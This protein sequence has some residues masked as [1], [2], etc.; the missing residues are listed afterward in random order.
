MADSTATIAPGGL[1]GTA[2]PTVMISN[3]AGVAL[4]S[5]LDANPSANVTINP[6][7]VE[8]PLTVYNQLASF[9][10][11]GPVTGSNALK[12]DMVAVGTNMYMAGESYDPLGELYGANGYAVANGTSFATPMLTGAAAMVLQSN[13]SWT[14]AQVKS[15][16]VDSATTDVTL[17]DSGDAVTAQS[18]GAGKLDAGLAMAATVTASPATISFGAITRLST[19]QQ[20]LLTNSGSSSVG[21]TIGNA[22]VH[23]ASGVAMTF[24]QSTLTLAA[25]ASTTL[26]VTLSGSVPSP[27]S[28]SGAVT[29]TGQNVSMRVPYLYLATSGTA[30]NI[31]PI[32]GNDYD[33]TVN[34]TTYIAFKLTDASGLPVTSTLIRFTA[35]SGDRVVAADATTNNYGI[36]LAEVLL[37]S[38]PGTYMF[39]ASAAGQTCTFTASARNVPAITAAG[40]VSAGSASAGTAVAPGSYIAIYG[41]AL[42]DTTASSIT[43]R[44]PLAIDSVNVSFDVPSAGISVP[45][46]LI[47]V[48]P[49]QV[50]VQIPWE[51][52]GQT[53]AQVKVTIDYTYGNVVTLP[54][55]TYAPAF[56]ET[57]TGVV[58]ALDA[59][60]NVISSTNPAFRGQTIALYANGVGPVTNTP[61]SG[62]PASSTV[63]SSTTQTPTVTIGGVAAP[64]VFSGLAP[65][66][67]GV[68]QINVT[69]PTSIG[70]GV[71]PIVLAIGGQT[72][73]ASGITVR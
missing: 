8:Q 72:S 10:S 13:P 24:S 29:I 7:E 15:A 2:T 27:G 30:S 6:A 64:V 53:A 46:H 32:Y 35:S 66:F 4:Q 3:S 73:K 51:L 19:S 9:S 5:Y 44:L 31:I 42:S 65:G 70:T 50:N 52:E 58:S 56:F 38:S 20:I 40:I 68:Y 16:L 48:S 26:T 18:I 71:Q 14:A 60:S 62:D 21:L 17:D 1:G 49:S 54:L 69:V 36:G 25:G 12:P 39:T 43:A 22:P 59:D 37:G 45:G 63:L 34:D 67:A 57:S 28:Y 61:A 33:G 55:S 23:A 47:F 41:S 11:Q